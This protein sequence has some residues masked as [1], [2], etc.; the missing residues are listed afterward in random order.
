MEPQ[1]FVSNGYLSKFVQFLLKCLEAPDPQ[2]SPSQVTRGS[3]SSS[4]DPDLVLCAI[5][6]MAIAVGHFITGYTELLLPDILRF[7]EGRRRREPSPEWLPEDLER[8]FRQQVPQQSL[9]RGVLGRAL[10]KDGHRALAC[11]I[12]LVKAAGPSM[13]NHIHSLIERMFLGTSKRY[14]FCGF[15]NLII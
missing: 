10:K 7:L 6:D 1:R 8:L 4:I 14:L 5:G 11:T 12:K 2:T 9:L 3:Q 13:V 15:L